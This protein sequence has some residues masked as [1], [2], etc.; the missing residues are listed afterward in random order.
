MHKK[1]ILDLVHERCVLEHDIEKGDEN[2]TKLQGDSLAPLFR[3]IHGLPGSGKSQ[4]LKWLRS[5]FL[6]VWSWEEGIHFQFVAPLNSM[7]DNIGGATLH[8]WSEVVW[9]DKRGRKVKPC[10]STDDNISTMG[11]KC[12]SLRFL[13]VDEI[14]RCGLSLRGDIEEATRKNAG[15]LFKFA[16]DDVIP[17]VFGAINAFLLGDFWQLPPTGQVAIMSNR[18]MVGDLG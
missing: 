15:R 12:N 3:L 14:E 11:V 4:T 13:F 7:A 2:D 16:K 10:G 5:Y 8:S 18:K 1:I 6:E 9:E 17:R